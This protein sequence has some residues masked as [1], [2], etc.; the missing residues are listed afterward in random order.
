MKASL[1]DLRIGT[2]S[3]VGRRLCSSAGLAVGLVALATAGVAQAA[4]S[5]SVTRPLNARGTTARTHRAAARPDGSSSSGTLY[6]NGSTGTDGT[7]C[8]LSNHPCQTI[9]YA[10]SIA[11]SGDTISVAK[12]TYPEQLTLTE[13][14]TIKGAGSSG[15]N[16]T[17]IAPT[18]V[19]SNDIDTDSSTPQ[20]AIVDFASG[21]TAGNLQGV[22]INGGGTAGAAAASLNGSCAGP[23]YIGVY[24]HDAS[25]SM[26]NVQIT[27]VEQT[28][29]LFGCQSGANGGVYVASDSGSTSAVSMTKLTVTAYEKNGITCDDVG[30]TCTITGAKVTG[31]G[32]IPTTT[33]SWEN[34][35]QNG[36]QVYGA[37]AAISQTTVQGDNYTSPQYSPPSNYTYYTAAGILVINAGT[38]SLS[39]NTVKDNDAN[40][41]AMWY[42]GY[43]L[44]P[45]SQGTWSITGNIASNATNDTG[46]VAGSTAVPVGDGFGDGIDLDGPSNVTVSGNT[47][48]TEKEY[49]IGLLD[50]TSATVS[51]NTT[52]SGSGEGIYVGDNPYTVNQVTGAASG[53][54]ANTGA[55]T[56]NVVSD[57]TAK[58]NKLDGIL[59]D[60]LAQDSGNTF[61]GNILTSNHRYDAEDLSTGSG[62]GGTANTWSGNACT[63][64]ADGSPEAT[65]TGS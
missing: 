39:D 17:I 60:I 34:Q 56:A 23:D 65:C 30:T 13:N 55:S 44:G 61:T 58:S 26:T 25:G 28:Q 42:P 46:T 63:P 35:A 2:P 31:L 33:A 20:A 22:E 62:T 32:P 41:Y 64:A 11:Q 27:G 50:A 15:A 1:S 18:T 49:G 45:A 38:L 24:Y 4:P 37:S 47:A 53:I 36:I 59:A 12:G 9:G 40:I 54:A 48:N 29:D 16:A 7:T 8:R 5:P 3:R 10:Y 14:I 43:G 21:V 6:V 19:T 52:S 51:G 57:N